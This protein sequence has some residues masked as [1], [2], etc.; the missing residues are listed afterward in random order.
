MNFFTCNLNQ[1]VSLLLSIAGENAISAERALEILTAEGIEVPGNTYVTQVLHLRSLF[2][3]L[4]P[5]VAKVKRG[6]RGGLYNP[7]KVRTAKQVQTSQRT[8]K[9]LRNLERKL[10][11]EIALQLAS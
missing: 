2:A 3:W 7:K 6:P 11:Q 5:E 8:L 9:V 10:K 1:V 4:K